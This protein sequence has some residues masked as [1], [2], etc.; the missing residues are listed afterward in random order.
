MKSTAQKPICA[1]EIRSLCL[2]QNKKFQLLLAV[3]EQGGVTCYESGQKTTS[4]LLAFD[5]KSCHQLIVDLVIEESQAGR[6]ILLLYLG[7]E[8]LPFYRSWELL[9]CG[10]E[11]ILFEEPKPRLAELITL[12]LERWLTV[13]NIIQSDRIKKT[14]IGSSRSWIDL[15]RQVV[16]NACFSQNSVLLQGETG[17]GKELI[18]RLIHDLDQR[19]EKGSLILLDCTTVVPSLSGSEFFGH[20][21]GAYT[22]AISIREGA[23]SLADGGT[24]FLD[25]IGELPL[26]L[27]AELLRVI[28]EGA[29]KRVGSNQW[30]KTNFR[31]ICATN[32][33]LKQE[34]AAGRFR[35]DLYYRISTSTCQL[36]TLRDRREDIPELTEHF[37]QEVLHLDYA[38]ALD[39]ALRNFLALYTYPGNIRE[40]RQLIHRISNRYPG[41]GVVTLGCLPF[42]DR[43]LLHNPELWQEKGLQEAIRLA[44]AN[45]ICL[46]EIKRI[47]AETALDIALEENSGNIQAVAKY[48]DVSDRTVQLHQATRRSGK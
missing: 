40:L 26:V 27:Q 29:Y 14:A 34:V 3:L 48:L 22:D 1:L 30:R 35:P 41:A 11:D 25:E 31:L 19:P 44:L 32:R 9:N 36:P 46:K 42:A 7:S 33:D 18:A 37:L 38:P 23:F 28:Q 47:A 39:N 16:D 6:R 17:T 10:A 43:E 21:K 12:R 2:A 5:E 4:L 20:E 13:E 15:L 24:L 45:G 8:K